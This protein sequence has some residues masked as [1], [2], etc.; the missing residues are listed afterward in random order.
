[1]LIT[2]ILNSFLKVIFK[3]AI[4][5]VARECLL[6]IIGVVSAL[7]RNN[8][9]QTNNRVFPYNMFLH[10]LRYKLATG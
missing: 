3:I 5:S 9:F 6:Y 2:N 1:M 10:A 8:H 4:H 7:T